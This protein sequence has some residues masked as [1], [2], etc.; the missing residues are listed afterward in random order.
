MKPLVFLLA[1]LVASV[2]KA[3]D[4][5]I[6]GLQERV[7]I[8]TD[9]WGVAHIYASN[10]HDLFFAQGY[11][12]AK[13]RLFQFEM[14]RRQAT[15]TMAAILGRRELKRDI[16]TR[17]HL[18]R[19]NLSQ[20]LNHYHP[21]GEAIV[22][23]FVDGINAYIRE[24]EAEPA[25]LPVEFDLL[26]IKPGRW[27]AAVVISRHQGLLSNVTTELRLGRAVALVGA[28][29]V[30]EL[31]WFRPG[32]PVMQLDP[33]IDGA[34]LAIEILDLYRAFRRPVQFKA[35]DI[36][37]EYRGD[38][39]SMALLAGADEAAIAVG[40]GSDGTGSNNWV[41]SGRFTQ[42]GYPYVVNDPHRSVAL[43]SLRYFVH[44]HAP[45]WN[46]IGGGEPVLPGVSIG[47]NEFGGWGLTVFGQDNE[48]L[49]V[50]DTNPADPGQYRYL[51]RWEEMQVIRD[52]IAIKDE[53]P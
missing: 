10:E 41:V 3:D 47:H 24:T 16:G 50:Y 20:E 1:V 4:I 25:M 5:A 2:V 11:N 33:A 9:R 26:G 32:D 22:N 37:A 38:D 17:L 14:W 34:L 13:D 6:Q 8:L 42:S 23:A 35:E 36:V 27:T 31:E 7:E 18:F 49:Y 52:G 51:D 29:T 40:D 45:G 12:A 53:S 46:V 19:R 30:K 15:G 44:L 39:K 28:K 43:P 21:R 48:D